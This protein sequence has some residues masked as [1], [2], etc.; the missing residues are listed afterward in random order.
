LD[1]RE[2]HREEMKKEKD[3]TNEVLGRFVTVG[4]EEIPLGGES[5]N[6]MFN[7]RMSVD[8]RE[9]PGLFS[10]LDTI[11]RAMVAD[12]FAHYVGHQFR[13]VVVVGSDS[14]EL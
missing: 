5:S 12:R 11:E 14:K 7:M 13:C 9:F 8:A 10:R 6:L 4:A 3:N 2:V 1:L